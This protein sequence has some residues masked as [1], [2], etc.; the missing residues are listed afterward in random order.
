MIAFFSDV[1]ANIEALSACLDHARGNGVGQLVFLG[2]L[3][4]GGADPQA[5]VDIVR[6][7]VELG[8]AIAVQGN[9]DVEID[10]WTR[11]KL[12]AESLAW[13]SS[14]PLSVREGNRCY[15]HSSAAAPE[16]WQYVDDPVSALASALASDAVWTFCGHVHRQALFFEAS[17]GRMAEFRPTPGVPLPVRR[18]RKWVAI[19]GS[20][21]QPRS[22]AYMLFD[23]RR[24]TLTFHRVPYDHAT[25][26]RKVRLAGLPEVVR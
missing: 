22:A 10:E 4:D 15:V 24:E 13:L 19:A 11:D 20:V 17:P 16:R 7:Q 18:K 12:S 14:L 9:H 23:E 26:A 21:G 6:A 8:M 2:D 5:V 3:V 1:H 25:A